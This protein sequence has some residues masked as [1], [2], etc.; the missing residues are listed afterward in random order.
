MLVDE[1]DK[2]VELSISWIF[3]GLIIFRNYI[4]RRKT[5]DFETRGNVISWGIY[6]SNDEIRLTG[7]ALGELAVGGFE[8]SAMTTPEKTRVKQEHRAKETLTME[9]R[10]RSVHPWFYRWRFDWNSYQPTFEF[11]WWTIV[12]GLVEIWSTEQSFPCLIDG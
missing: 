5:G 12:S 2:I 11:H 10:R 9:H 6:L 1:L 4:D 8:L 7:I 3:H